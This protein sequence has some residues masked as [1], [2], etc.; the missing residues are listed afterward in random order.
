MV[1]DGTT[2][3][4][5]SVDSAVTEAY[6]IED[7]KLTVND[8]NSKV[9]IFNAGG[10]KVYEGTCNGVEL[11]RFGHGIFILKVYCEDGE[12]KSYKLIF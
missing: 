4:I 7:G 2:V 8:G 12:P 1:N 9:E 3:G 5:G 6:T 11:G 10:L